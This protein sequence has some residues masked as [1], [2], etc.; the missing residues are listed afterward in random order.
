MAVFYMIGT[1]F[2]QG[3]SF[4]DYEKAGGKAIW[5]VASFD[6]LIFFSS[7]LFLCAA[8]LLLTN[9]G[10][11][12]YERYPSLFAKR[13][14]PDK[15]EPTRSLKLTRHN[16]QSQTE[17][18]K[19]LKDEMGF[20]L[21]SKDNTWIVMEKGLS[22]RRLTWLYHAGIILCFVGFIITWL[23]AFEGSITLKPGKA[24]EIAPKTTGNLSSLWQKKEPPTEWALILDGFQTEYVE[25]AKL[26]YPKDKFSRLAIG[27]GWQLPRYEIKSD[28]LAPKDWKS[29]L[30]VARGV[31]TIAQKTIEI[32]D[33]LKHDG[34]TFYQEGFEQRLKVR[35][36]NNPIPLEVKA[37][38]ELIV[39]GLDEPVKFGTVRT[40][41]VTRLD[42]SVDKIKP[43]VMARSA[44]KSA[45]KHEVKPERLDLHG[46]IELDGA[47]LTLVG[48]EESSVISY[49]YDPG[50]LVLWF[51][52]IFVLITMTLRFYTGYYF[53]AYNIALSNGSV[54]L[55]VHVRAS[56]L[57][58]DTDKLYK[59]M[60]HLLER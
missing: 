30:R 9:L 37:D 60:A 45:L 21:V 46:S 12:C 44:G 41:R 10:I 29:S 22:R 20:R 11:C 33:P 25:T 4:S 54:F 55:D 59:R 3:A 50:V 5:F 13:V 28:N 49:R 38:E 23:F 57:G 14:F 51:S 35:V 6:L 40:G 56:G 42:G 8:L 31:K 15:F 47:F 24:V 36:G 19:V 2:P 34:Y 16:D 43:Y 27:L 17:V 1:I 52:G 58:A 7:P 53:L 26:D 32:N 48:F 39:P 18:S